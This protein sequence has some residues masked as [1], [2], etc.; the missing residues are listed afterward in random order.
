VSALS[1]LS[2]ESSYLALSPRSQLAIR[3][4]CCYWSLFLNIAGTNIAV[5]QVSIPAR[6]H[7][8]S[9]VPFMIKFMV[10]SG[11]L[12]QEASAANVKEN[13]YE[14]HLHMILQI[15]ADWPSVLVGDENWLC[16]A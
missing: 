5:V 12:T 15:S 16:D 2:R 4:G 9:L 11:H 7:S 3:E 10:S 8:A 1:V 6:A 13:V 14:L